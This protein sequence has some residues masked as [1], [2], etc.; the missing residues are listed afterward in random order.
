MEARVQHRKQ[1]GRLAGAGRRVKLIH[2]IFVAEVDLLVAVLL[3]VFGQHFGLFDRGGAHQN[4]LEPRIRP[5]DLGEDRGVFFVLATVNLIVFVETRHRQ[6]GRDFEHVELVDVEQ[7]VGFGRCRT[8]HA[9]ELRVHSEIV[10]EGDRSQ[11]LVFRLNRLMLLGLQR[12]M[13]AFRIAPARHHAAGELVDDHDLV[14]ADDVILVAR[15][16]RVRAQ[17][18]V[19]VVHDRDVLDVIERLALELTGV[20]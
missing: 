9:G 15:K 8:G 11:R 5:L 14:V 17:R 6:V 4:R 7:F 2:R 18:L 19:D 13:Q 12:L 1:L 20:A 10:L 3:E 16:Q